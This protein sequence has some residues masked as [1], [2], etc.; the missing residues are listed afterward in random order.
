MML[1]YGIFTA[2]YSTSCLRDNLLKDLPTPS[3][4]VSVDA[5]EWRADRFHA[6]TLLSM[7]T[8]ALGVFC[9]VY[10]NRILWS[11]NASIDADTHCVHALN[12]HWRTLEHSRRFNCQNIFYLSTSC[13]IH[14]KRIVFLNWMVSFPQRKKVI[15]YLAFNKCSDILQLS[16]DYTDNQMFC[17]GYATYLYSMGLE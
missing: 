16:M 17:S 10:L 14:I 6:L 15:S 9:T 7:L 13:D 5:W 4:S 2:T 3:G 12:V 11:I 1:R 8:L